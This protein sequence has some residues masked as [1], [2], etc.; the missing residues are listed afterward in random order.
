M[1]E[2]ATNAVMLTQE[3]CSQLMAK[4]NSFCKGDIIYSTARAENRQITVLHK[5]QSDDNIAMRF[6][7][8]TEGS[9]R[10]SIQEMQY[11]RFI[12]TMAEMVEKYQI[13][14]PN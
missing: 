1:T 6:T 8:I 12:R 2:W 3:I 9:K 7:A 11:E 14:F 13:G 4:I 5:K 10:N